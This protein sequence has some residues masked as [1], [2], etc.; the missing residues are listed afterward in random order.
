V[1]SPDPCLRWDFGDEQTA[2]L[3]VATTKHTFTTV[4]T[5]TKAFTVILRV[6]DDL[7]ASDTTVQN[8]KPNP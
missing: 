7:D 6:V 8:I 1:I 4:Q 5:E 3:T 2:S